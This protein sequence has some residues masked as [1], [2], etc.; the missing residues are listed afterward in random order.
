MHTG[1]AAMENSVAV[2]QKIKN[3][4]I[5]ASSNS[6]LGRHTK[7][8]KSGTQRDLYTH[9]HRMIHNMRNRSNLNVH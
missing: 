8:L 7:E 1:I 6:T 9:T 4:V 3:R 5:I 2:P